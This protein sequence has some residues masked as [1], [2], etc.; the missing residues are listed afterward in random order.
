MM[1]TPSLHRALFSSTLVLTFAFTGKAAFA[2][3]PAPAG[4][5]PPAAVAEPA[6]VAPAPAADTAPAEAAESAPA[7]ADAAPS[8]STDASLSA[9]A[10]PA[11]E[12]KPKP[13]PYSLPFQLRPAA[14][15]NVVRSDTAFAFMENPKNGN[16]GMTVVSTL[17][18][19]YKIVDEFAPLVRVGV[20]ANDPPEAPATATAPAP[21]GAFGFLN[22]V[23]GGTYAPK[24]GPNLKL[25]FFLGL[26][27]PVGSGGGN[28]PNPENVIANNPFGIRAR[29]AMDNAMFATN[30]FTIFPGVGFAY[31]AKGFTAQVEATVLQLMRVR[32]E[33]V[34]K[35]SSKTNLTSG[36]HV[37]YF[38]LPVLSIGAEY[39]YQRWLSTPAAIEADEKLPEADQQGLRDQ[40]TVAI[41]PRFHFQIGETTWIRPAVAFAVPLDDPMSDWKYKILQL[42]IPVVF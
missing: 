16:K 25:A 8:A 23:I 2:Q 22:P 38:V 41:G 14:T 28:D 10:A 37:G 36:V 34:Q 39:R 1:T 26:T 11:A 15:V 27:I 32:G 19:S 42:D 33:D 21:E 20:V 4:D 17:L 3:E 6:A 35:D 31:V 9:P 30:D 40:S 24:L 5:V 12:S 18:A 13:P 29:S 7:S